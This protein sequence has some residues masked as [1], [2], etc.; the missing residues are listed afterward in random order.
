M[1]DI[2]VEMQSKE[3]EVAVL[4]QVDV[5]VEMQSKEQEVAVLQQAMEQLMAERE[6]ENRELMTNSAWEE[7]RGSV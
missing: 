1:I 7:Y 3:Q 6:A 4:Q 2:G 5:G